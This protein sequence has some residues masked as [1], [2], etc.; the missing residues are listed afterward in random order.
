MTAIALQHRDHI[1][2]RVAQ[3]EYLATIARDLGL[4]G[5]GQAI[6]N[7]LANDP[8]YQNARE[9]G[10]EAKLAAR[11]AEVE[12]ERNP[13][14]V[15]RARELLSHARWRAE[16]EC[17]ARWGQKSHVEIS[18]SVTIDRA[19]RLRRARERIVQGEVIPP[20]IVAEAPQLA[21]PEE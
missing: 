8:E 12:A 2:A 4:S 16:R 9:F 5:K 10:L 3:G 6:S 14:L 17:P 11:E 15:P 20:G 18:G 1:I 19:D 7:H 13:K 21:P